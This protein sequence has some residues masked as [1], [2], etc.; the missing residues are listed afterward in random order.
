MSAPVN[1]GVRG[2]LTLTWGGTTGCEPPMSFE[3]TPDWTAVVR[4][5][6]SLHGVKEV[7][8]DEQLQA[9]LPKEPAGPAPAL[10]AVREVGKGRLAVVGIRTNWLF[11]PPYNCPTA[12]A[13]L[14]AGAAGKPSD[15]LRVFANAFRWLA[16]P[17]LAAGLGGATTPDAVLNPP[18][19]AWTAP[20]LWDW[21]QL[22]PLQDAPQV[23]GLIGARTALSTGTGTVA[24]Y[25][26]AARAAGLQYIVFLEDS[27]KMDQAKWDQLVK[28]CA[29]ASDATFAAIPGL[30]YEDAQGDH[31]YAFSDDVRFPKPPCCW[32]MAGW[33][34]R[35]ACAP[36]PISTT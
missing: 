26:Q 25:A 16:A 8:H 14:S 1:D 22:S 30:T 24:D 31:L 35:S 3:L 21:T 28:Q 2:V 20:P 23:K 27:L 19:Q 18:V 17:S 11:T 36:A 13:M 29:D 5:A 7:R 15:W 12:E 34:P 10:M 32:R 6:A 9:W 4:G 33:R